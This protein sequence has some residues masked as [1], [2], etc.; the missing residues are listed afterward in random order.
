MTHE[1]KAM[2]HE[3]KA[4]VLHCNGGVAAPSLDQCPASGPASF[5]PKPRPV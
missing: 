2:T 5:H 4:I 3:C 1:C